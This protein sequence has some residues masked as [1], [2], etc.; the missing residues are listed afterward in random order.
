MQQMHMHKAVTRR[1][2]AKKLLSRWRQ[3]EYSVYRAI[4][5]FTAFDPLISRLHRPIFVDLVCSCSKTPR[6]I[7]YDSNVLFNWSGKS[8][9]QNIFLAIIDPPLN[10]ILMFSAFKQA[11]ESSGINLNSGFS[12]P[13]SANFQVF[14]DILSIFTHFQVFFLKIHSHACLKLLAL[15]CVLPMLFKNS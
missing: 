14:L 5:S 3:S 7:L 11:W 9:T 8:Y 4:V 10:I 6:S 12:V 15:Q 2:E 1:V 13:H